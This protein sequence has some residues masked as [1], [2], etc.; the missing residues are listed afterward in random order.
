MNDA[1]VVQRRVSW[2]ELCQVNGI[3]CGKCGNNCCNGGY[4]TLRDG[5]PCD[6]CP[7]AYTEQ[8]RLWAGDPYTPISPH[9]PNPIHK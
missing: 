1:D 7:S 4:G 2:C 8:D 9:S 3:I 6:V 5:S